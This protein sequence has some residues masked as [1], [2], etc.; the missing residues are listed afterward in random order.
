MS[1]EHLD[2]IFE[3]TCK[4]MNDDFN[5]MLRKNT[6]IMQKQLTDAC[7]LTM[8]QNI[9]RQL[10]T[11][12]YE[13]IKDLN[14][15]LFDLDYGEN[16]EC[17]GRKDMIK[18][19]M[20]KSVIINKINELLNG[21]IKNHEY[22][23]DVCVFHKKLEN[24]YNSRTRGPNAVLY[25]VTVTNAGNIFTFK[26][27]LEPIKNSNNIP[28]SGKNKGT[29]TLV[30]EIINN[31]MLT[32]H[33]IDIIKSYPI[34]RIMNYHTINNSYYCKV[35]EINLYDLDFMYTKLIEYYTFYIKNCHK[36]VQTTNECCICFE[37]MNKKITL[38][39]CGH[40]Q[41]CRNCMK[42][43]PRCPMCNNT[44]MDL[45]EIFL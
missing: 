37:R 4:L 34:K 19:T 43:T 29:I 5:K 31:V 6:E 15:Y 2:T 35:S 27:K 44:Y 8:K 16:D 32:D 7:N 9:H 17:Y 11:L 18:K 3:E 40:T 36:G 45:F 1:L 14:E 10:F 41:T 42:N 25:I 22:F 13:K 38:I 33:D 26:F 24:I 20:Q 39:P 30:N 28:I 21:K 23:V 12:N